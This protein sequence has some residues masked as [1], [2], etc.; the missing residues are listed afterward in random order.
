MSKLFHN[1]DSDSNTSLFES[2]DFSNTNYVAGISHHVIGYAT[3]LDENNFVGLHIFHMNSGDMEVTT[4]DEPNGLG[5][6]YSVKATSIRGIYGISI[7]Y[8]RC[9]HI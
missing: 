2:W 8:G 7:G 6:Y 9:K 5:E 4:G 3:Q 1:K